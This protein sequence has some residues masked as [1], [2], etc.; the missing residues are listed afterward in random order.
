MDVVRSAADIDEVLAR[1]ERGEVS[2]SK[3]EE[4]LGNANLAVFN[5][6]EVFGEEAWSKPLRYS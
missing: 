6:E 3:L 2:F 1:L 5:Q 4:V